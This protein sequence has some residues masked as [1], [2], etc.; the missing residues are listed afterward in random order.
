[1]SCKWGQSY[2][3]LPWSSARFIL[4]HW[5][6]L[7]ILVIAGLFGH[8]SKASWRSRYVPGQSLTIWIPVSS[9]SPQKRH[10]E[11]AIILRF[12]MCLF[13]WQWPVIIPTTS[14][15]VVRLRVEVN[16]LFWYVTELRK[17][18]VWLYCC[19]DFQIS[20]H[21][22][23]K[24]SRMCSLKKDFDIGRS[25]SGALQFILLPYLASASASSFPV[26]CECPF[27]QET[28]RLYFW[29]VQESCWIRVCLVLPMQPC[30]LSK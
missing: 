12:V 27:I 28:V 11:S 7:V 5:T 2:V 25:G 26:L 6:N 14:L 8:N 22:R 16:L 30:Y 21:L 19:Q 3:L 24:I 10:V 13:S 1:M 18:F 9:A 15:R 23:V 29:L 20:S 17:D 4:S